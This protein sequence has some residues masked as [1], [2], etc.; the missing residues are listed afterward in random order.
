MPNI[1][2]D[3]SPYLPKEPKSISNYMASQLF[4]IWTLDRTT[5]S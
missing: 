3:S 5:I 2:N 1:E 4:N